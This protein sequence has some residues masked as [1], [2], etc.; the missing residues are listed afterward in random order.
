MSRTQCLDCNS[1]DGLA[2][3]DNG[4]YCFSC[5]KNTYTK[6]LGIDNGIIKAKL[7]LPEPSEW[8]PQ[9]IEFLKQYH[10]NEDIINDKTYCFWDSKYQRICFPIFYK[11][12]CHTVVV[13]VWM[14]S[15]DKKPKWLLAGEY[16]YLYKHYYFP[17]PPYPAPRYNSLCI[18]EDPIS[19]IRVS[20]FMACVALGSTSCKDSHLLEAIEYYDKIYI[21]LDGDHAGLAGA[22]KLRN[23]IKLLKKV[24]II[25]SRKDPKCYSDEYIE[26]ILSEY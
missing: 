25:Y 1:S 17:C 7:S 10:V 24:R 2:T 20:K 14:R 21:W 9:A 5:Q 12:T 4:T 18:V 11:M 13:F 6:N 19:C 8:N 23:K 22:L 3:Y 16:K 15:L 26:E